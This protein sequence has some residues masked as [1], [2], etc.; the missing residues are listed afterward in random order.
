[1][2]MILNEWIRWGLACLAKNPSR[3]TNIQSNGS[4]F[5]QYFVVNMYSDFLQR[6]AC[7][8][9]LTRE[10]FLSKQQQEKAN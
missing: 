5:H 4:N 3:I 9:G 1:M 8:I 10:T 2:T 6:Q 7:S